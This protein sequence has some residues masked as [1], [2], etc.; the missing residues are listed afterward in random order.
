[1]CSPLQSHSHLIQDGQGK[2]HPSAVLLLLWSFGQRTSSC[3]DMEPQPVSTSP[4]KTNRVKVVA[5]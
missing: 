4:E 5:Y 3:V 1:M 2:C